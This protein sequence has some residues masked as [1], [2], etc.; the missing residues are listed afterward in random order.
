VGGWLYATNSPLWALLSIIHPVLSSLFCFIFFWSV[1]TAPDA[2]F[3]FLSSDHL[4]NEGHDLRTIDNIGTRAACPVHLVHLPHEDYR[5]V[6]SNMYEV[7]N[8]VAPGKGGFKEHKAMGRRGGAH[9]RSRRPLDHFFDGVE[10]ATAAAAGP[11]PPPQSKGKPKGS[12][13]GGGSKKKMKKKKGSGGGGGGGG[14]D[15][16]PSAVMAKVAKQIKKKRQQG[17]L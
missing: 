1:L 16:T 10:A 17:H 14:D 13:A 9:R 3:F 12:K 11:P 4:P 5:H 8:K 2:A 6:K 15:G 7:Q